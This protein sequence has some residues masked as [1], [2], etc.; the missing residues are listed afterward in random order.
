[1]RVIFLKD[2]P[3]VAK[4]YEVKEV[5]DGYARNFLLPNKLAKLATPENL[6]WL[7]SALKKFE[8][9]A[10]QEFKEVADLV[11]RID[12]LEVEI[13]VKVGD[14][15]QLFEGVTP[16]KIANALKQMGFDVKKNQI[17]LK[18]PIREVG[19]HSV[20]LKFDHNLE[21]EIKVIISPQ[22]NVSGNEEED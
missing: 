17:N 2:V 8:E 16:V 11:S 15:G 10:S 5:A 19:E 3:G 6:K 4:K 9:K 1:M 21:A 22:E 12:G 14:K 7:K 13:P 18:D 20:K